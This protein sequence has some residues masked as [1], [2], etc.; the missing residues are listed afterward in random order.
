MEPVDAGDIVREAI[1]GSMPLVNERNGSIVADIGKLPVVRGDAEAL[2]GAVR[3]LITNGLKY[4]GSDPQ[5]TVAAFNGGDTV[6]ISVED[7]GIG[8]SDRE[9]KRIF[10]PFFRSREVI[11]AQIHGNG[12][13]LSLVKEIVDAHGGTISVDSRPG[14]GT[15]VTLEIPA[16]REAV[17]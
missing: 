3:N 7:Q 17:Q 14:R 11:D 8:I 13:G 10:E 15:K 4:G 16:I 9:V 12:L 6:K 1:E 5:L 2:T